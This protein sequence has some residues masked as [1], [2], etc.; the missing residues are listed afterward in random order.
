MDYLEK[1]KKPVAAV[2]DKGEKKNAQNPKYKFY[3]NRRVLNG[4]GKFLKQG[5]I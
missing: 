5:L 4:I 3:K 1:P 2:L